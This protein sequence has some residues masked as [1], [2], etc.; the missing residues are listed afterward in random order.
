MND[1]ESATVKQDFFDYEAL[2]MLQNPAD[3]TNMD[4]MDP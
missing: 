2:L 3:G 1:F 4:D